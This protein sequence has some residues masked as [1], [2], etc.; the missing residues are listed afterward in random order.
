MLKFFWYYGLFLVSIEQAK[1]QFPAECVAAASSKCCPLHR[2]NG[3]ECGGINAGEC[4]PVTFTG[5]CDVNQAWFPY[6][7]V[8]VC[9]GN[10]AGARCDLCQAGF[11]GPTCTEQEPK[12]IRREWNQHSELDKN[13]IM[14]T[15]NSMKRHNFV[16]EY[17]NYLDGRAVSDY[18]AHVLMHSQTFYNPNN[19]DLSYA[20]SGS[21]FL[22]W[23]R[24]FLIHM[25][26]VFLGHLRVL[27][28]QTLVTALPYLNWTEKDSI[29]SILSPT[30][31]GGSGNTQKDNQIED[32]AF[33]TWKTLDSR[34]SVSDRRIR[35]TYNR[36]TAYSHTNS[37]PVPKWSTVLGIVNSLHHY[38]THFPGLHHVL[39]EALSI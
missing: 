3:F 20:H 6:T 23:H 34:G 16:L 26:T 22:A 9:K 18:D 17:A 30:Y 11:S 12:R 10:Y 13:Q 29:T 31:F 5:R 24:Y 39:M 8:C 14:T 35:R 25:E 32:G 37:H 15:F 19:T 2:L 33:A 28:P 21:A 27:Y 36:S 4:Q 7:H 38:M 1:G